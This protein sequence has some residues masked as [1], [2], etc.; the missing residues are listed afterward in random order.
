MKTPLHKSVRRGEGSIIRFDMTEI[1]ELVAALG[2]RPNAVSEH[3]L[4]RL[5]QAQ[6]DAHEEAAA[7]AEHERLADPLGAARL[8]FRGWT[9]A[10]EADRTAELYVR[11]G[12]F[13]MDT[14]VGKASG[15][16]YGV[17][18]AF[19]KRENVVRKPWQS[20]ER[21]DII[22]DAWQF[23]V[24]SHKRRTWLMGEQDP[25]SYEETVEGGRAFLANAKAILAKR[26]HGASVV[27][28]RWSNTVQDL[29]LP[30]YKI[31]DQFGGL[32]HHGSASEIG[33]WGSH[34]LQVVR[35]VGLVKVAVG[36]FTTLR[37][38]Q[39]HPTYDMLVVDDAN[40][41]S[42]ANRT[43]PFWCETGDAW[44]IAVKGVAAT[45]ITKTTLL[46]GPTLRHEACFPVFAT[47]GEA[48]AYAATL[49]L[50]HVTEKIQRGRG[51]PLRTPSE[52]EPAPVTF[53]DAT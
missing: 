3:L 5:K 14:D 1:D 47:R 6:E 8:A 49:D 15:W 48:V 10:S 52:T 4:P 41:H 17:R 43:G 24:I 51:V 34:D 9:R 11:H 22:R 26:R 21:E 38:S 30:S 46:A 19:D 20:D 32:A 18:G 28:G 27:G 35:G 23:C 33:G 31:G 50:A 45:R 39:W 44:S 37:G 16:R 53:A 40:D 7:W 42:H 36:H 12:D 2:D 29:D 13:I 25:A